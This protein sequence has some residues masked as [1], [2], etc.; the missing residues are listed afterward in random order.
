MSERTVV[1][2]PMQDGAAGRHVLVVEDDPGLRTAIA[3][4][5]ENEGFRVS[6]A[7][8]GRAG[9][10]LAVASLPDLVVSD[11]AMPH[12][13]GHQLL[14]ELRGNPA[15]EAIPVIFLS[16]RTSDADVRTGMDLGADDYVPKPFRKADLLRAVRAR[17]K[18]REATEAEFRR[19]MERQPGARPPDEGQQRLEAG[20]RAALRDDAFA[21]HYQ[22]KVAIRGRLLVGAEAL[23]RWPRAD[24]GFVPPAEFIPVAEA[25]DLIIDVGNWV[26]RCAMLQVAAWEKGGIE[27][28]HVAVNVS[29]RQLESADFIPGL[30]RLAAEAGVATG[31]VQLEV[32]ETS[33][34][35]DM[36]RAAAVLTA[37]RDLGFTIALDDFGTGYSS[38]GHLN[39]LPLDEL[40]LDRSFV[41]D[42]PVSARARSIARAVVEM[43]HRMELVV[44]AEGVETREQLAVL[45]ELGCD[46]GQ[47][48]LF[49]KP[50][51]VDEMEARCR[52]ADWG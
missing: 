26:L 11:V 17:L 12:V 29:A 18:R 23:I 36:A 2:A 37:A 27:P 21:L 50:I 42:M 8:D 52:L 48:Y 44:V 45:E 3:R 31:R 49:S 39:R 4:F 13:D 30:Q 9:L 14:A 16:A 15:T 24:G 51:T 32:T 22:P 33:V 19:R 5:L 7:A 40:K 25:T 20:I 10:A 46:V 41:V 47:G 38:L 43:A 28:P 34:A 6:A 35:R 1:P